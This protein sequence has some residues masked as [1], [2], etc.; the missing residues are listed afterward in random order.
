MNLLYWKY[1]GVKMR[2]RND[3]QKENKREKN[4]N[5]PRFCNEL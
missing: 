5:I 4:Y 1:L 2:C 3:I